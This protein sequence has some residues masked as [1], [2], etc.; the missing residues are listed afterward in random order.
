M[1]YLNEGMGGGGTCFTELG[2]TFEPRTGLAVLWNNLKQDGTPNTF[3]KHSG[4]PVT[5]GHKIIITKWFRAIGEG[6]VF[7]E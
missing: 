1:V 7:F 5:S 2:H 6:P 4:E 3:T